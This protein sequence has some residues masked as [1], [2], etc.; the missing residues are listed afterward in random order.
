MKMLLRVLWISGSRS[1]KLDDTHYGNSQANLLQ[2]DEVSETEVTRYVSNFLHGGSTM[3]GRPYDDTTSF[4]GWL[5][6]LLPVIDPACN[7]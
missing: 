4:T 6:D 5:P 3:F 7:W 2:R 1:P